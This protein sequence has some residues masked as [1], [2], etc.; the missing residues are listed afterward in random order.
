MSLMPQCLGFIDHV[1]YAMTC[2]V[3]KVNGRTSN[4]EI[5][6][7]GN[8]IVRENL[9]SVERTSVGFYIIEKWMSMANGISPCKH[10]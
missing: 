10:G 2:S 5:K 1:N 9:V 3:L 6:W 8:I 4:T 7:L